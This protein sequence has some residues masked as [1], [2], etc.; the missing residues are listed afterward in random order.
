MPRMI[1][2]NLPVADLDKSMAF[3][4]ALGFTNNP[5]FTDDSGA[6]MV[7]SDTIYVMLLTHNKWRTFTDRPIP[8]TDSSEVMLAISFDS[9]EDVDA[10]TDTAGKNGGLADVNPL[11]DHGFM[12]G[13]DCTDLDGHIWEAFWMDP[14]VATG[15]V[16]P[17]S[18]D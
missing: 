15:E 8:S 16:V 17:E 1:F 4:A 2:V 6:C 9:K 3:Y 13:R 10:F 14:A 7:L 12:Y 11:Q 18:A 5:L